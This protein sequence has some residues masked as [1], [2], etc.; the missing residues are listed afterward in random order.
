M[1]KQQEEVDNKFNFC[2]IYDEPNSKWSPSQSFENT[3]RNIVSIIVKELS[4]K[5]Q[6][7]EID[8]AKHIKG[9]LEF[10][11]LLTE[12]ELLY[13]KDVYN[14]IEKKFTN[15]I[16]TIIK[17]VECRRMRFGFDFPEE[18]V[19]NTSQTQRKKE[20][21][22]Q[23]NLPT[24]KNRESIEESEKM[25]IEQLEETIRIQNEEI[26]ALKLG[27][28]QFQRLKKSCLEILSVPQMG[29]ST[30]SISFLK[31]TISNT[32]SK[33]YLKRIETEFVALKSLL[34][35]YPKKLDQLL[36]LFHGEVAND[37]ELI[38]STPEESQIAF[39]KLMLEIE[40]VKKSS[41]QNEH[42][43]NR[44][45]NVVS[46]DLDAQ[47]EI[48]S[49][50]IEEKHK[51]IDTNLESNDEVEFDFGK[52]IIKLLD[53]F[54]KVKLCS[55]S[56]N[57]NKFLEIFGCFV[58]IQKELRDEIKS[59]KNTKKGLS[60]SNE[61]SPLNVTDEDLLLNR[62]GELKNID[63]IINKVRVLTC[64]YIKNIDYREALEKFSDKKMVINYLF[65]SRNNEL[66]AELGVVRKQLEDLNLFKKMSELKLQE[67]ESQKAKLYEELVE[68]KAKLLVP[69]NSSNTLV[70]MSRNTI[71]DLQNTISQLNTVNKKLEEE[72]KLINAEKFAFSTNLEIL[73]SDYRQMNES[74]LIE[75]QKL[76]SLFKAKE[77]LLSEEKNEVEQ[78]R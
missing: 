28:K 2:D 55:F 50:K 34:I 20:V 41:L 51:V 74:Y 72:K 43:A 46:T 4:E 8:F 76:V 10:H 53:E 39:E 70:D 78:M 23:I 7:E 22:D 52:D 32:D 6:L 11:K 27:N 71:A 73:H 58:Q 61:P 24:K 36:R 65:T 64:K 67:I 19:N 30:E 18:E 21:T 31:E 38:L 54:K 29:V 60:D 56:N 25:E 49:S 57:Q 35:G 40:K 63:Q 13:N 12:K 16:S 69:N 1:S 47:Q 45:P 9:V 26:E 33:P 66:F 62:I 77:S 44:S 15:N 17:L 37:P 14:K 59:L 42:L 68:V 48:Y 3:L 5:S 75:Q